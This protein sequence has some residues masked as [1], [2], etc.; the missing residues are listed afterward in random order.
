MSEMVNGNPGERSYE[1]AYSR[2]EEIVQALEHGEL[3]LEESL[4]L[5]EEGVQLAK[6]CNGKLDSAE[7][8][9][10]VLLG[11]E[12]NEPKIGNFRVGMEEA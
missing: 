4:T 10:Q 6:Y 8:R 2:L 11:F 3:S 5:F 12:G 7:G 9:L 1:E